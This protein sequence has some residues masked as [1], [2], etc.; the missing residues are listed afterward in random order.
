M[1]VL[2]QVDEEATAT[3]CPDP[4][5]LAAHVVAANSIELD[6]QGSASPAEMA[7]DSDGIALGEL[8]YVGVDRGQLVVDLVSVETVSGTP[9][10]D[11][12][13][14]TV[15]FSAVPGTSPLGPESLQGVQVLAS[16]YENEAAA[17]G[18]E[19]DIE[20]L[21]LACDRA[22]PAAA[23]HFTPTRDGWPLQP[24]IEQILEL[25]ADPPELIDGP[26]VRRGGL[27]NL[28]EIQ[29]FQGFTPMTTTGRLIL[30]DDC[31][32]IET[33]G[34]ATPVV[35]PQATSW[36]ADESAVWL[37]DGE[38]VDLGTTLSVAGIAMPAAW[39]RYEFGLQAG[40]AIENCS[41]S[42]PESTVL[43]I[44]TIATT[45]P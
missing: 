4:V 18:F 3:S 33:D 2:T 7:Q 15:Y 27:R 13:S 20:G 31:L 21:W 37:P 40:L 22:A 10:P 43:V 11:E 42:D 30:V 5:G 45:E 14:A 36:R 9:F 32:L 1:T 41:L 19:V 34:K 28:S 44:D 25:I 35:W 38:T 17:G 29:G 8:D 6:Y 26:V 12:L 16:L 24:S 39:V 23:A